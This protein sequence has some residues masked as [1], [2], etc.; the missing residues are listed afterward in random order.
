MCSS[1]PRLSRLS[2]LAADSRKPG[3]L[4]FR[5]WGCR[6]LH[7]SGMPEPDWPKGLHPRRPAPPP[8][9]P[10]AAEKRLPNTVEPRCARDTPH[11]RAT[12]AQGCGF[13]DALLSVEDWPLPWRHWLAGPRLQSLLVCYER[14][15]LG[16]REVE[17]L[18]ALPLL[19]RIVELDLY[20]VRMG[21]DGARARRRPPICQLAFPSAEFQPDRRRGRRVPSGVPAP[22]EPADPQ[23]ELL[24]HRRPSAP[25]PGRF[26][27]PDPA[28]DAEVVGGSQTMCEVEP[29]PNLIGD[30]AARQ[31]RPLQ[32]SPGWSSSAVPQ[33]HRRPRSPRPR[34]FTVPATRP[35]P[36]HSGQP[37]SPGSL[38]RLEERFGKRLGSACGEWDSPR[39]SGN[40]SKQAGGVAGL[41]EPREP[42]GCPAQ[43]SK[44]VL[45]AARDRPRPGT[46]DGVVLSEPRA[47]AEVLARILSG[48][49]SR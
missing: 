8:Q 26:S 23:V 42:S 43:R 34:Q 13:P 14:T 48:A 30:E 37:D 45:L 32:L 24:Q 39:L 44:S 5:A 12:P 25:C 21:P 4:G 35:R 47:C 16:D 36:E 46:G 7:P 2:L 40:R 28:N 15:D 31:S 20:C 38:G 6:R 3:R 19:E 22:G 29:E 1:L 49:T 10:P 9:L 27:L 33:C 17:Q 41:S 11:F 18:A